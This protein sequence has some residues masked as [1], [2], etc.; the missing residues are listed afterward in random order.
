MFKDKLFGDWNL[1]DVVGNGIGAQQNAMKATLCDLLAGK[2]LNLEIGPQTQAQKIE[3]ER[4]DTM[5]RCIN[6]SINQHV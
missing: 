6:H 3:M 4:I 2:Y 1:C 5:W